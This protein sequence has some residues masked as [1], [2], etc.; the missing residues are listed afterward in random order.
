MTFGSQPKK[1]KKDFSWTIIYQQLLRLI[2]FINDFK[3]GIFGR[4]SLSDKVSTLG[5]FHA[6]NTHYSFIALSLYTFLKLLLRYPF[7]IIFCYFRYP[8]ILLFLFLFIVMF[9]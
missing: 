3:F 6:L 9:L 1:K 5:T 2:F 4:P 7:I 8:F